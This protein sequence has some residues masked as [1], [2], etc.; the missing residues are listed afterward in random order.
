M[1]L[2]QRWVKAKEFWTNLI[3]LKDQDV[4]I[5]PEVYLLVSADAE[6]DPVEVDMLVILKSA[7]AV[8]ILIDLF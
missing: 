8:P 2:I 3:N 6:I 1:G 7:S 5:D 4:S